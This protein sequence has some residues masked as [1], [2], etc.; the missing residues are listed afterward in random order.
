M[1]ATIKLCPFCGCNFVLMR[2]THHNMESWMEC[3]KCR[4]QGPRV[5]ALNDYKLDD[6]AEAERVALAAW[7][8]RE[9]VK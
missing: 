6:L 3:Q 9:G 1:N 2:G 7:N 8:K 5:V 4:A